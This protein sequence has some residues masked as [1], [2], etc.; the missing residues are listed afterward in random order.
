MEIGGIC[1][2]TLDRQ[3]EIGRYSKV[4]KWEKLLGAGGNDCGAWLLEAL[5]LSNRG[6]S[7]FEPGGRVGHRRRVHFGVYWWTY[8]VSLYGRSGGGSYASRK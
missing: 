6:E 8:F 2:R 3:Q 5:T 1:L 7:G 4:R